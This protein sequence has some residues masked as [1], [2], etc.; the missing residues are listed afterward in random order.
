MKYIKI[1]ATKFNVAFSEWINK[2]DALEK[3]P[4]LVRNQMEYT[5]YQGVIDAYKWININKENDD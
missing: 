1:E 4:Q 3:I 5:Y 2:R